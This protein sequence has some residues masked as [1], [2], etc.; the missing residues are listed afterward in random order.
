M[1]L[2]SAIVAGTG[3][4]LLWTDAHG[5]RALLPARRE[6]ATPR[7]RF[8]KWLVQAGLDDIDARE[9]VGV[10]AALF[11][12]SAA[13]ADAVFG[14]LLPAFVCGAFT[15][16]FPPRRIGAAAPLAWPRPR[17]AWPRMIEEPHPHR[18]VGPVDPQA[19]FEVGRRGPVELGPAFAAAQ[20][21]WL[22]STDFGR[23]LKVLKDRLADPTADAACE[24]LLIANDLGGVDLDRRLTALAEERLSGHPGP[25]GRARPSSRGSASAIPLTA[26]P[27]SRLARRVDPSGACSFRAPQPSASKPMSRVA[28]VSITMSISRTCL[29]RFSPPPGD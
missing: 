19:L 12:L 28:I 18:V 17:G 14:G 7:G 21:E 9:F 13:C 29:P 15:A 16:T 5:Q 4:H 23:T 25:Q 24:T 20:R 26:R 11:I 6:P 3:T 22:L 1:A 8:Q 27:R 10:M 2:V